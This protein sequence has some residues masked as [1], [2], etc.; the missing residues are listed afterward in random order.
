MPLAIY[1]VFKYTN[2]KYNVDDFELLPRYTGVGMQTRGHSMKL[3]ETKRNE[4]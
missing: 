4:S 2:K 3:N 1:R